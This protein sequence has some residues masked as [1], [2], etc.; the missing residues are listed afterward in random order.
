MASMKGKAHNS[1]K[2]LG[3]KKVDWKVAPYDEEMESPYEAW[4]VFR[5]LS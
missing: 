5:K 2:Y 4:G 3:V 1:P